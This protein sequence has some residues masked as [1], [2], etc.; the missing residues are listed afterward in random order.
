MAR[1]SLPQPGEP[2]QLGEFLQGDYRHPAVY[3]LHDE[4]AL[5][6]VGQTTNLMWR[7]NQHL[8][9]GAK[10]FDAVAFAM[11]CVS[12]L[13]EVEGHYIRE[14]VPH[15]N[16]CGIAETVRREQG[17]IPDNPPLHEIDGEDCV[18]SL[19]LSRIMG[20]D[21]AFAKELMGLLGKT[22]IPLG[23]AF[24]L[25][26]TFKQPEDWKPRDPAGFR[27]IV[28]TAMLE[29]VD[30]PELPPEALAA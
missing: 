1:G 28:P 5:V 8:Q 13:L 23:R 17:Y 22:H 16:R 20:C 25:A 3:F 11:C 30:D 9:E 7:I 26:V 12:R 19:G 24:E 4:G 27:A 29:P 18:Q 15:Y 2:I 6:Y 10:T 14:Y 21:R